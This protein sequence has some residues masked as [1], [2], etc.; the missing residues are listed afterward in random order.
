MIID[1]DNEIR[2]CGWNALGQLGLDDNDNRYVFKKVNTKKSED[3]NE[4]IKII[5]PN[6]FRKL[7]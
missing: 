4:P 3:K 1:Q 2:V 5:L 6:N 7:S